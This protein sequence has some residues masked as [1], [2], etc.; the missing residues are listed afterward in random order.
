MLAYHSIDNL[1][2]FEEQI[3]HIARWYVPIP[4]DQ[5]ARVKNTSGQRLVWLTFDDGDPSIVDFGLDVLARH[6]VPATAFICP[7]VIDTSEPYWW[8]V[9]EEAASLGLIVDGTKVNRNQVAHLKMVH[10]KQRRDRVQRIRASLLEAHP[11]A[12]RRRQLTTRELE[13]WVQA[14]HTIGNHTWDHPVLDTCDIQDQRFQVEAG[15]SWLSDRFGVTRL[16]A[17]PNGNYTEEVHRLLTELG[18]EVGALFDHRVQLGDAM[19]LSRVLVNASDPL[20]EF[21][22][23][24]SGLHPRLHRVFGKTRRLSLDR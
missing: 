13:Q 7:G 11:I 5:V 16:F 6:G 19:T 22:A 23:K 18:Y 3:A 24:V 10:D 2:S 17:Y 21:I 9:V 8:Q 4:G 20:D 15:H 14:G 12:S 1:S